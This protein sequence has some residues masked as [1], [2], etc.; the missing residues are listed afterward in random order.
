MAYV[1]GN[2]PEA[3]KYRLLTANFDGTDQKVLYIAPLT[4]LAR[5]LTWSP[6]GKKIAYPELQPE[7][8]LGGINLF[9]LNSG[10]LQTLT[11]AD[12]GY[13][14]NGLVAGATWSIRYLPPE[15]TQ[16]R[17]RPDRI[18]LRFGRPSASHFS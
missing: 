7:N 16:L 8:A 9:D 6:D 1:R 11:F 5:S 15:R 17:P 3:G 18:R 4:I 2:D 12:K 10:K 14:G 13:L